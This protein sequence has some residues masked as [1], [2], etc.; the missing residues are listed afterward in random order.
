[1]KKSHKKEDWYNER[2][3]EL[4][5]LMKYYNHSDNTKFDWAKYDIDID[6]ISKLE[7][8]SK[9]TIMDDL[10]ALAKA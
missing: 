3:D 4:F 6:N 2:C 7:N 5:K 9:L 8:N 10:D 1:M